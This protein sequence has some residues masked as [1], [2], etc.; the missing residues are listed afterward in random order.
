MRNRHWR[1]SLSISALLVVAGCSQAYWQGVAQNLA[2][3][4][5][6]SNAS[7]DRVCVKYQTES[8]WS[9]GYSVEGRI[10]KGSELNQRTHTF[11]YNAFSTYVVVFWA[12]G[13]ASILELAFYFGSI[14]IYGV[15]ATD[16]RGRKWQVSKTSLCY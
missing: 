12:Q 14:P 2:S 3:Y 8:G 9:H 4:N 15:D 11:D 10:L 6:T 13:E 16:Q 5:A 7:Q 1:A